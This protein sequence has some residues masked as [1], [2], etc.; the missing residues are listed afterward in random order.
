MK[1]I[2]LY[3][4]ILIASVW[5]G[6]RVAESPGYVLLTYQQTAIETTL[7]FALF[8]VI[9]GFALTYFLLRVFHNT[10]SVPAKI[11]GWSERRQKRKARKLQQQGLMI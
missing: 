1:R 10:F 11:S 4:L 9:V 7:W 2:L 8:A 6:L 3:V 5:L